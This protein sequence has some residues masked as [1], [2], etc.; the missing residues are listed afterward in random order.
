MTLDQLRY[1]VAVAK[2]SHVG[3]ASKALAIS[4]SAVSHALNGLSEE[5]GIPILIKVG[6]NIALTAQ[7]EQLSHQV[8]DILT[9][10]D[11]LEDRFRSLDLELK[12]SL[13]I[14]AT[15]SIPS[16]IAAVAIA[17]FQETHPKVL[18]ECS[19]KRSIAVIQDVLD[20]IVDMGVC[21]NPQS[22]PS[23]NLETI[24]SE[25][26]IVAANKSHPVFNVA[27]SKRS[28]TLKKYPC[29]MPMSSFGVENCQ[30]H[31]ALIAMGL[32][33]PISFQF[34]D[35]FSCVEYLMHSSGWSMIPESMM[36]CNKDYL[37]KVLDLDASAVA[38]VALITLKSRGQNA[39][40]RA[41]MDT[42]RSTNQNIKL[43]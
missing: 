22:H 28:E 37:G 2:T 24:T 4:P 12:G 6:R 20:S 30:L 21:F 11:S 16:K 17:R 1:L 8:Q 43:R 23:I 25:N 7:A 10:I 26:L 29:A 33:I 40:M 36:V 19:S 38:T 3:L 42:L 39:V 27:K 41:F 15:S 18:I 34:D 13:R 31:P 5:L 32:N 9:Q 35:Y 14:S